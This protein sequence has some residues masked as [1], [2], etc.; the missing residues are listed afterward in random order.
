[1][2]FPRT[3]TFQ[4]GNEYNFESFLACSD[5]LRKPFTISS[6]SSS[7]KMEEESTISLQH[8]LDMPAATSSS[9]GPDGGMNGGENGK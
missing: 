9:P 5:R 6:V 3:I 7:L 1:M 8:P 4:F 2:P